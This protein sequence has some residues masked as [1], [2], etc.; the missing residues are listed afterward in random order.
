MCDAGRNFV[1][2]QGGS[3]RTQRTRTIKSVV[4]ALI[5]ETKLP[6]D[7]P[8]VID[9]ALVVL[10]S[11]GVNIHGI[12]P[13]GQLD[14]LIAA[15]VRRTRNGAAPEQGQFVPTVRAVQHLLD[16]SGSASVGA[17]LVQRHVEGLDRDTTLMTTVKKLAEKKLGQC[18]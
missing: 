9:D 8:Y 5:S 14:S 6:A 11:M 18:G 4:A 2:T 3:P 10:Q 7:G 1:P 17:T 13:T 15:Q 16:Y 12:P